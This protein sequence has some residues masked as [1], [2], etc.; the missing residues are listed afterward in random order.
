MQCFLLVTKQMEPIPESIETV[1]DW[2]DTTI[3]VSGG[4][5]LVSGRHM[6]LQG[7]ES[8]FVDW[9][10]PFERVW[11]TKPGTSPMMQQFVSVGIKE[12]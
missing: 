10:R 7:E 12:V 6:W 9:L 4:N 1:Q 3:H 11:M 2:G 8:D 5:F